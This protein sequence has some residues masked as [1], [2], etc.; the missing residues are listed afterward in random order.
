MG[1][2][3]PMDNCFHCH[4]DIAKD[5]PSHKE[6]EFDT[7]AS[8]GCPNFHDTQALYTDFLTRHRN[9][10]DTLQ[11]PLVIPRTS[12]KAAAAPLTALQSDAPPA[13]A[14][15]NLILQQWSATEH[16]RAGVNCSGCHNIA[17]DA[18]KWTDNPG[19]RACQSCHEGEASGFLAGKHGMRLAAGLPPM[20]PAEARLP[21]AP[22]S[23][24]RKLGCTSC[25][26]SHDFDTRHAAVDACLECHAD[27]HSLAYKAS[28]H[29]ALWRAESNGNGAVGSGVSCAT[30]H[31]PREIHD[32]GGDGAVRVQHNQNFNLRPNEKMIRPVCLSCHGLGFSIDA[33]ADQALIERNFNGRPSRHVESVDMAVRK[34][35]K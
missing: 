32:A 25:H 2:T 30:C 15:T 11:V 14:K 6:F 20:S 5:R 4:S 12:A 31:L 24:S 22:E 23:H 9:D 27:K 19:Y 33:L 34:T 35:A 16:A 29:F 21:M 13:A 3:L 26:K 1:V 10:P 7:C 28:P 17:S 8:A 18:G